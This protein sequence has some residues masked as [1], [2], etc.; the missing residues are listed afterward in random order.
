MQ[1]LSERQSRFAHAIL[2]GDTP[3]QEGFGGAVPV[4]A[5]LRIHRNTVIGALVNAL[6]LSYPS[7]LAL[8]GEAFFDQVA[9]DFA[10]RHPPA[11]ARLNGYGEAFGGFLADHAPSLAYLGDVA[12]LDWAMERALCQSQATR[13]YALAPGVALQW[14]VSLSALL[15][16][17]P[18]AEIRSALG[19]DAALAA[20]DLAPHDH[21]LLLWR[22]G[23]TVMTRQVGAASAAF[24][25]AMLAGEGAETALARAAAHAP[26]AP[27]LI[28]AE[29]FA[30]SFCT[31]LSGDPA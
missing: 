16:H 22:N 6:Q 27:T 19:D 8:V 31:I 29:I 23:R 1:S 4:A 5:A 3:A 17:H 24:V 15:L 10:C 30:A 21:W 7:V 2:S 14:P 25:T 26:D 11:A 18:A 20:I 9:A 13:Q 12:R 28:Q